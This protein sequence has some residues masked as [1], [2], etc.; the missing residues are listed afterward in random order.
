MKKTLAVVAIVAASLTAMAGVSTAF[1]WGDGCG[2]D[3][4]YTPIKI[5]GNNGWGNGGDPRNPGSD[6]G[7][8]AGTKMRSKLR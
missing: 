4:G 7:G 5:K 6:N 2:C 8:T 3:G 1:A